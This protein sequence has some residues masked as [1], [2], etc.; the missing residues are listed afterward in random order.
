MAKVIYLFF[1]QSSESSL[2][3][4]YTEKGVTLRSV[5]FFSDDLMVWK[6]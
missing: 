3:N 4:S 2:H 6:N 1:K 5:Y